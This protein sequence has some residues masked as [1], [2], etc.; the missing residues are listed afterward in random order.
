[1]NPLLCSNNTS[2]ENFENYFFNPFDFQEILSDDGSDPDLNFFNDQ[3]E[4]VNSPYFTIEEFSSSSQNLLKNSFSILHIN[5]RSLNKNFEK[6]LGYLSVVK[7]EFSIIA[8][9]ETWCNDDKADKN[10]LW[11]IPNY[12]PIHQIRKNGQKGGGVALYIH[13]NFN[14]KIHKK[15]NI[16][17]D[18]IECI[19]IEIIRKNNKN[20]I[21]SCIYRPPRGDSQKFLDEIK[22]LTGKIKKQEKPLFL[23]GDFNINSLD[24]SRNIFVRDFFNLVFQNGIFPVINR[25]TRVTKTSATVIDHILT[26][27]I[28]D[29]QLQSGIVKTDI[30]DHFAVF[31]LIKTDLEQ[32]NIKNIVIKRDINEN[33][34]EHFKFLFNSIDWNLVTQTSTPNDSYNIFLDKFVQIY[35]QAFPERK[36]EIK[37][38]NLISPWIT[39]GLKKSSRKKQRLYEKFLKQRNSKNEEAYKV[40][41]NLFEK[42]KKQS[43]K[44]YFQNKF[45]K[46]ENDIKNTWKIM[47]SIIGKSSVHNDNFPKSLSIDKEE[48]TDK[49]IIAEKFN[50]YFINVGSNLAAKIQPSSIILN[51]SSRYH[52]RSS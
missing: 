16:N 44:L 34:I 12:T 30:S 31:S 18:D 25:P 1:M 23:T 19:T 49:K 11:Q 51:V 2:E 7:G 27:T 28:I 20:I 38:K 36:I 9:T 17:S 10:S 21:I 39:R 50:S 15:E 42:L 33:S 32:S 22:N 52:Y 46:Y 29:W 48:I 47:K 14:F 41:K 43:K 37:T 40:Y 45:K 35:D 24:Y 4:A 13:N 26:N 8:L 5:I 3:F 6:L